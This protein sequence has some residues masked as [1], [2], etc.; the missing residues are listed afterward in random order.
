M[1]VLWSWHGFVVPKKLSCPGLP[2]R[3]QFRSIPVPSSIPWHVPRLFRSRFRSGI[4]YPSR[5]IVVVAFRGFSWRFNMV[6]VPFHV[7][8]GASGVIA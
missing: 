2:F 7:V 1:R 4:Q 8:V 6:F 5:S 3:L